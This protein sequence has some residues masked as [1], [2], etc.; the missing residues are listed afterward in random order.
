MTTPIFTPYSTLRPMMPASLPTWIPDLLDQMR[1]ES[2]RIYEQIYW[3]VP[4]TFKLVARG[5]EDKPIYLPNAKTIVET[6]HR[7]TATDMAVSV[8][9]TLIQGATDVD[10]AAYQQVW[11]DMFTRERFWSKF[12]G[13]KRYGLIRGD[14]LWYIL[15]DPTKLPGSR[16]SIRPLDPG[17]YF[18]IW[19]DDDVDKIIG[20]HIVDQVLDA[21]GNPEIHKTTYLKPGSPRN[22][23]QFITVEEGFFKLDDWGGPKAKPSR[24]IRP[25]TV[26][27]G[28]TRLP[29]YHIK[30]FDE[31]SNPFGSSEIRGVERILAATNQGISDEE[32]ALALEGLGA[33]WTDA[34]PPTDEANNVVPWNLGPGR[35]I[36]VPPGSSINRVAGISSVTSSQEHLKFLISRLREASS[37]PD[38]AIGNIDVSVAQ[39]G[40]ALALQFAPILAHTAE[41]DVSIKEVH[42][43][44][45][46]DIQNEWLPVFES[47]SVTGLRVDP[48]VGDKIPV[49][50]T[51][52][53]AELNDMF[54][55]SVISAEYYRSEAEKLGYVFPADIAG[56]ITTEAESR[57]LAADPFGARISQELAAAGG[58]ASAQ[59]QAVQGNPGGQ[60]TQGQ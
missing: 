57:A 60:A 18:P 37:V 55:R 4:D 52:K 16:I 9:P 23:G 17:S 43:Q 3:N 8:R 49:D 45:F 11:D 34:P 47:I 56:Q 59:G 40:I 54:D 26:I 38:V 39:S 10:R 50:R 53:L 24:I 51:A 44:M 35:F 41:K 2:Y 19:A 46:Y 58:V 12:Q 7:F 14:W 29:V 36:E 33:Y 31:P 27:P 6:T 1:I 20:C 32:L 15:A 22:V 13:N 42:S 30:N 21:E 25:V 5:T 28:I 48:I